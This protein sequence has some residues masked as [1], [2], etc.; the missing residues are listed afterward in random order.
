MIDLKKQN[1]NYTPPIQGKRVEDT[2]MLTPG[3]HE[4]YATGTNDVAKRF[5]SKSKPYGKLGAKGF[6]P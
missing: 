3:A 1:F 2:K 6:A 4:Q 5:E